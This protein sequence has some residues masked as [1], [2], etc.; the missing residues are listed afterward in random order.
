MPVSELEKKPEQIM[1]KTNRPNKMPRGV[2]FKSVIF[3]NFTV[4]YFLGI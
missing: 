1:R 4:N 3:L 2:S